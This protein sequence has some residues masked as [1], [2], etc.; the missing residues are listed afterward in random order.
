MNTRFL[1]EKRKSNMRSLILAAAVFLAAILLFLMGT[2]TLR[3]KTG[4]E[5]LR[6]LQTAISRD[7]ARCYSLEGAYP[8][9]LEI[10][11]KNYGL[12]YDEERFFV[13]YHPNGKNLLPTVTII[14]REAWK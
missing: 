9:S 7:I 13:D 2:G 12:V 14:D 3:D 8:E 10:L 11:K 6:T 5:A 1:R 4:E